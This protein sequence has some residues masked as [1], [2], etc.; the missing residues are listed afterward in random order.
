MP[1]GNVNIMTFTTEDAEERTKVNR[2][3]ISS[4]KK[5]GDHGK[6]MSDNLVPRYTSL[7]LESC[8]PYASYEEFFRELMEHI[9]THDDLEM[10]AENDDQ[11][12][13]DSCCFT[14]WI[15]DKKTNHGHLIKLEIQHTTSGRTVLIFRDLNKQNSQQQ[16]S[17][18]IWNLVKSIATTKLESIRPLTMAAMDSMSSISSDDDSGDLNDS[19]DDILLCSAPSANITG[20]TIMGKTKNSSD[21][22]RIN[23]ND[24]VVRNLLEGMQKESDS[25]INDRLASIVTLLEHRDYGEENIEHIRQQYPELIDLAEE[26][27]NQVRSRPVERNL[28][29]LINFYA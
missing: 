9:E 13:Y 20:S 12:Y 29:K 14:G 28:R 4:K 6:L 11:H 15:F 8:L 26:R 17:Y 18:F 25:A 27:I 5:T 21:N 1:P 3:K 16:G 2:L 22:L 7:G 19:T 24:Y 10:D 23:G